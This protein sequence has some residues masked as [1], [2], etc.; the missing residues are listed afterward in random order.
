M[1]VIEQ[2]R[3]LPLCRHKDDVRPLAPIQIDKELVRALR[4]S[5]ADNGVAMGRIAELAISRLLSEL[6]SQTEIAA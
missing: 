2:V 4:R 6:A 3:K 5:A 1:S